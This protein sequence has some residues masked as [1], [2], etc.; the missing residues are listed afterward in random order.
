M[1]SWF[2]EFITFIVSL[3]K[4]WGTLLTGGALAA[5]LS[6]WSIVSGRSTPLHIGWIFLWLTLIMAAFFSWRKQWREAENNFVQIG[7]AALM[8]LRKNK[9]SPHADTILK[10]YIGKRLKLNANF[11]DIADVAFFV[12]I[13]HFECEDVSISA[14]VAPWTA[15]RFLPLPRLSK[16]TITG[17]ITEIRSLGISIS[18]IEIVP[19]PTAIETQSIPKEVVA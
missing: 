2:R 3:F 7:P 9:T 14:L 15:K 1:S 8:H 17:T 19:T 12:K 18:G 5:A 10:P 13:L 16:L 6:I 11:M 4:E